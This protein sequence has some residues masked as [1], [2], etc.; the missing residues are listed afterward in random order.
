MTFQEALAEAG[1]KPHL[2]LGNGFSIA[3]KPDIFS[4]ASLFDECLKQKCISQ[5]A[6][7]VFKGFNTKDFEVVIRSLNDA[8]KVLSA[9]KKDRALNR[10]LSNDAKVIRKC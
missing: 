7:K 1:K 5:Q 2:L 9:Y 4:Y 3:L 10:Q 8:S 6:M